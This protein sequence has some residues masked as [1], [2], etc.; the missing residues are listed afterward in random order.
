LKPYIQRVE[1]VASVST[2]GLVEDMFEVRL[3]AE[4]IEGL[5]DKLAASVSD[6]LAEA[7]E[8]L[9]DAQSEID[10]G[11]SKLDDA[12]DELD[13]QET[14]TSKELAKYTKQLNKAL[15]T[16]S[17]YEATLTSLKASK[18]ALEAEKKA[19]EDAGVQDS[20][21]AMNTLF[22]SLQATLSDESVAE[23]YGLSASD[24]PVDIDEAVEDSEKLANAVTVLK[25]MGQSDTAESLTRE[26]LENLVNIVET[27]IPQIDTELANLK[28]EIAAA[29]AALKQVKAAVEEALDKYEEVEAGKITASAAFGSSLA[30]ISSGQSSLDEAQETLDSSVEDYEEARDA[31][32]EQANLDELLTIDTLSSLIAAQNFE[33]PAGYIGESD[34]DTADQWL[35]KVGDL[36]ESQDDLEKLVLTHV[37]GVGDIS[38]EDIATVTVIDDSEESYC[39]INGDPGVLLSIYKSGSAGTSKVADALHE[40][41]DDLAE[42]DENLHL[43]P[44]MDQGDYIDMFLNSIIGN[45]VQGAILAVIVLIIFLRS[46]KPTLVVAFSIPFSV[47]LAV[48]VMYFTGISLNIMSMSGLALAIG[49]L[50][51]NSIVVTENIYRL[52]GKG[53]EAPRAAL[54][55]GKQVASAI[56][57]STI[58]TICVFLPMIFTTGIVSDLMIPFALTISFALLASLFVALTVA[59]AMGSVLLKSS[60]REEWSFFKKI[61]DAYGKVLGWFLDHKAIPL[62]VATGL[63]AFSIWGVTNMGAVLLPSMASDQIYVNVQMDEGTSRED[64]YTKADGITD[65]ILQVEGITEV[66]AITNLSDAFTSTLGADNDNYTFFSYYLVLDESVDS[67]S[68]L[69]TLVD[70]VNTAL[71]DETGCEIEIE[72]SGS[73]DFSSMMSS[74]LALQIKGKDVDT[75]IDIS[76]DV[77]G[78]VGEIEGFENVSNGQEDAEE[79]IHVVVDRAKAANYQLTVAQI[80]QTLMERLETEGDATTLTVDG[81]DID[82]VIVD[83]T[84]VL[85]MENINDVEFDVTEKNDDGEEETVTHSLD[86]FASVTRE[87]GLFSISAEN[88]THTLE[89]TAET[90]E[91]YN[92]TRLTEQVESKLAAYDLPSGYTIDTGGETEEVRDMLSQMM[93]LMALG[94]VLVYL[95]MVAQFQS[96]LSPFIILFTVPLAF[97]GGFLGLMASGDQISIVSLLGLLVLMGTVVNN[98]IVFVD[99]VN[100]LRIAGVDKRTAI[101]RT[102]RTRMRPIVMTALTTI[103]AMITMVFSGDFAAGLSRGMAVVVS[104]GL[105]YATFMTLFIVPILYDIMYRKRP[106]AVHFGEDLEE[107]IDLNEE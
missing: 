7:K 78:I 79:V 73:M 30:Q 64:C 11:S 102:G 97:T 19:Y 41:L 65:K 43:S 68:K 31:A 33:M 12:A 52:R 17:A 9:D 101:I 90:A 21:D 14:K 93:K 45:M 28:T 49:M 13:E 54:W 70:N 85:T 74:G 39:R 57:S 46:V 32:L 89:V 44:L 61:R 60:I 94:I 8:A 51:D 40:A 82:V 55:G 34:E 80:Y 66:G 37:D 59:P 36:V 35:L 26:T 76:E 20:Y 48:L 99:Y 18:A 27:R 3:D 1:G 69:N 106:H 100:Q 38:V 10:S 56:I 88:G 77:M 15:A 47:L 81:D 5:N 84:D 4:K 24:V 67:V 16:Q 29:K 50:V 42:T 96:L 95:V 86:E 105:A 25:A 98:G 104:A 71:A 107:E 103:L 62:V 2:I 58:T 72:E 75:L 87:E 23:L 6:E 22:A 91:G 63:L 83:E 92:T 53:I